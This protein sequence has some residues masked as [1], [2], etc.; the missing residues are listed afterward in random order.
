MTQPLPAVLAID[1]GNSKTEAVL[2]AADGSLLASVRGA[3]SNPQTCGGLDAAFAVLS[4]LVAQAAAQ[5]GLPGGDGGPVAERCSACLAGAD[6][7]DEERQ[8]TELVAARG[9]SRSAQVVNDTFAV[10]RA[11]LDDAAGQHWGVGV[12]CGAGINC[13]G[14]APDGRVT[15]FLSLGQ[16]SGDWG[17]GSDL[18]RD[19]LWHAARAEDGRGPA[20]ML[21]TAVPE[22][23]GLE[24][25]RD[26]TIGRYQ[27]KISGADL[28]GLVPVLFAA[29]GQ[30]D[31]VAVRLL[32]AQADEIV[33]MAC[34]AARRLDLAGAAMPVVLGGSI[35]TSRD[36]LLTGRLSQRFAEE[37]PAAMMR[38]VDVPPVAGAALLG[39][40]ATGADEAAA[41]RLRASYPAP[42]RA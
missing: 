40:D 39:L 38:I 11:G 37:L 35:L 36:P 22:H 29:A 26:V 33:T 3:A 41:A 12:T 7:P 21:A 10:L 25:V 31:E 30:G 2:V 15:R 8:L 27:G 5:A 17:G 34:V 1:G 20:T 28:H 32:A 42:V 18:A 4:G 9:W 13:V 23:F 24:Q 19:A 16:D 14:I 6:L